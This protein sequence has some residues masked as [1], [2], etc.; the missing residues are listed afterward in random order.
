M[1]FNAYLDWQTLC[2]FLPGFPG[3]LCISE[4]HHNSAQG[5]CHWRRDSKMGSEECQNLPRRVG[6][7]MNFEEEKCVLGK[8][9][10]E[11]NRI[12]QGQE[13]ILCG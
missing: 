11:E 2:P 6:G 13:E 10:E 9:G 1:I 5:R 12:C 7:E 8:H 3:S 4:S